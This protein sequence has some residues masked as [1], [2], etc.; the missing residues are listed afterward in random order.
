MSRTVVRDN[1]GVRQTFSTHCTRTRLDR[2]KIGPEQSGF[3]FTFAWRLSSDVPAISRLL[4]LLLPRFPLLAQKRRQT[5]EE[6]GRMKN[7]RVTNIR[8]VSQFYS[9]ADEPYLASFS[10]EQF[11]AP[12]RAQ[13]PADEPFRDP[14]DDFRH[15][16]HVKRPTAIFLLQQMCTRYRALCCAPWTASGTRRISRCVRFA[17]ERGTNEFRVIAGI[18]ARRVITTVCGGISIF[19]RSA[20]DERACLFPADD[21][22][23]RARA[24]LYII[25]LLTILI[26]RLARTNR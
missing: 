11:E 18:I 19:N 24:Q 9:P 16:P 17:C 7:A 25:V 3:S 20:R 6:E 1:D 15:I 22:R 10:P 4:L 14:D 2:I 13:L 26:S 8:R 5:C 12:S 23:A 21:N